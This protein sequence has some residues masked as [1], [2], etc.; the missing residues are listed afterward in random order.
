MANSIAVARIVLVCQP[1]HSF[2]A[3]ARVIVYSLLFFYA[4]GRRIPGNVKPVD[5]LRIQVA[6]INSLEV[7]NCSFAVTRHKFWKLT[8]DGTPWRFSWFL[9]FVSLFL[10]WRHI[11]SHRAYDM[12]VDE[13]EQPRSPNTW[14]C[15]A[16]RTA[17]KRIIERKRK[18]KSRIRNRKPV[19][20]NFRARSHLVT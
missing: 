7:S 11:M 1:L 6:S 10:G 2:I 9:F 16:S 4:R 14:G 19:D 12:R 13:M 18:R 5:S 3:V 17:I 15:G 20:Y 8:L